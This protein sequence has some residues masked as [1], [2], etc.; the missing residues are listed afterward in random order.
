[1]GGG[2]ATEP[3]LLDFLCEYWHKLDVWHHFWIINPFLNS[4]TAT[5]FLLLFFPHP[6]FVLQ[7]WP[8]ACTEMVHADSESTLKTYLSLMLQF[9][10][11]LRELRLRHFLTTS[12][13]VSLLSSEM[14]RRSRTLKLRSCKRQH[15]KPFSGFGKM[16][17]NKAD[18]ELI[19]ADKEQ[20]ISIQLPKSQKE[21]PKEKHVRY[22]SCAKLLYSKEMK[23][24]YLYILSKLVFCHVIQKKKKRKNW[25]KTPSRNTK[26]NLTRQI[27]AM[28]LLVVTVYNSVPYAWCEGV[29]SQY[30]H[31]LSFFLLSLRL[32][33]I[34]LSD[35]NTL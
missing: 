1:M 20:N 30:E 35:L 31:S 26:Q 2:R 29:L 23:K 7:T 3:F 4:L 24:L 8:S 22:A 6:K 27:N 14:C 11:R 25:E 34:P 12:I 19:R 18:G 33:I 15:T 13:T 10:Q 16:M 9:R 17:L 21:I 28:K 32:S 5:K